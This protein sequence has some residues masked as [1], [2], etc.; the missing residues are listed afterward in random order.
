MVALL[1]VSG[2]LYF[3]HAAMA[4]KVKNAIEGRERRIEAGVEMDS[5][6]EIER[7]HS[8]ARERWKHISAG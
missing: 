7:R 5:Q 3:V 6:E 1:M 2:V 4:W 8:E